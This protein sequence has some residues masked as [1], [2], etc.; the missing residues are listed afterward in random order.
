MSSI[1][2]SRGAS[3]TFSAGTVDHARSGVADDAPSRI[4]DGLR[5]EP[6]GAAVE[7]DGGGAIVAVEVADEVFS[8]AGRLS[9]LYQVPLVKSI[10][11]QSIFGIDSIG[12]RPKF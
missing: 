3:G 9:K 2:G 11:T 8:K 10:L 7:V 5:P 6:M 12:G 4:R 1:A